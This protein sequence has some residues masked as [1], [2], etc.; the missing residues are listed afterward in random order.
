M[1]LELDHVV[2]AAADL[3]AACDAFEAAT[4]CR[5]GGGGPHDGRGTHNALVS[6]GPGVYLELIAPDPAQPADEAV[7]AAFGAFE[8]PAPWHWAVRARDLADVATMLRAAGAS[9]TPAIPMTRSLPDGAELAW[10]LMA[11]PG[12]GGASPFY[13]DWQRSPHPSQSAPRLDASLHLDVRLDRALPFEVDA[14]TPHAVR[15]DTGS[16]RLDVTLDLGAK[17]SAWSTEAPP[18]FFG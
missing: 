9:P 17:R 5:P 14:P 4:G 7:R 11:L 13:I 3:D 6:L 2:F 1:H 16:P 8:A 18:G 10:A 12:H 15:C